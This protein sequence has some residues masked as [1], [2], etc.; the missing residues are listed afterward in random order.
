MSYQES[1]AI[2]LERTRRSVLS[3]K[4]HMVFALCRE[5][6]HKLDSERVCNQITELL[7]LATSDITKVAEQIANE[8][9]KLRKQLEKTKRELKKVKESVQ[10]NY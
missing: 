4:T 2:R 6:Q 5:N 10:W 9:E 3:E 7:E 8:N 1:R